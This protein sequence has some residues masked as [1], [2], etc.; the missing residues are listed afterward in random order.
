MIGFEEGFADSWNAKIVYA[1][2]GFGKTTNANALNT[3]LNS[4]SN[5]SAKGN[6]EII[7]L[8][9][10]SKS[11]KEFFKSNYNTYS[12]RRLEQESFFLR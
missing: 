8:Y 12:I 2:N 5:N 11:V 1:P 3:Y 6:V 10:G 4:T 9:A 7:K